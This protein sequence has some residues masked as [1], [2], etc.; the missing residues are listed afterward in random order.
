MNS[1]NS[2]TTDTC[3]LLL[4][5]TDRIDLRRCDK[6]VALSKLSTYYTW[7]NIKNLKY[8]LQNEMRNLNYLVDH[9]LYQIFK[10]ILNISKKNIRQLLITLQ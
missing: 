9:K 10:I 1:E 3:R 7:K 8:Q 5:L 4:N 2:K 6:Y